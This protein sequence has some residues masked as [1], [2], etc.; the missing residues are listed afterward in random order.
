M[1]R[2]GA[3]WRLSESV[4]PGLELGFARLYI[5]ARTLA[6]VA[7]N[8]PIGESLRYLVD[9]P[10]DERGKVPKLK[11]QEVLLFANPVAGRAGEVQLSGPGAQQ[12]YSPELEARL[13]PILADLV[14]A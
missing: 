9:V 2:S 11:K 3:R 1:R 14:A 7:G 13:R 12:M 8:A 6:L 4:H 10:L 5:E